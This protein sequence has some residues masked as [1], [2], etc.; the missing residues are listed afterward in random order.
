MLDTTRWM[1]HLFVANDTQPKL[2]RKC[3]T[4]TS[5]SRVEMAGLQRGRKAEPAGVDVG[6]ETIHSPSLA[7][8]ISTM[9]RTVYREL[10]GPYDDV[11]MQAGRWSILAEKLGFGVSANGPDGTGSDVANGK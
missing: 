11:A 6:T 5:K 9:I 8:T 1:A 7:V 10:A 3:G 4:G 2:Y